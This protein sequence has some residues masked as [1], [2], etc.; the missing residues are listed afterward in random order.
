MTEPVTRITKLVLII[1]FAAWLTGCDDSKACNLELTH[2]RNSWTLVAEGPIVGSSAGERAKSINDGEE[3]RHYR[4]SL[5]AMIGLFSNE[6]TFD[7]AWSSRVAAGLKEVEAAHAVVDKS[8]GDD[9]FCKE[10]WRFPENAA[11]QA[12][13]AV[14]LCA[15]SSQ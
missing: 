14:N 13:K 11:A 1:S 10:L 2:A 4:K 7:K 3:G 12:Q 9:A 6:L 15:G 5:K 8:C